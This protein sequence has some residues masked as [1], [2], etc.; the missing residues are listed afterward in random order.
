MNKMEVKTS[1]CTYTIFIE[2]GLLD[3]IEYYLPE[4][5][6]SRKLFLISNPTVYALYGKKLEEQLKKANFII[7]TALMP[8]GEEY[9][10]M[11]EMMKILDQ[12][13]EKQLERNSVILALGGGVVGDLAGFVASIYQRGIDFVQIPTTLLS[14]VDSSVGGKVAVNHSQGKNLIGSFHQP[15]SVIIDPLS[16]LT[17]NDREYRAGLGEV[18]KYGI[19]YDENFFS[20]MEDN[21]SAINNKEIN[22]I[23]ELIFRSCQIKSKIVAEDE[24]EYGVRALLNL[25]HTF[26]HA[27]EK[28]THYQK[29]RHGEAVAMGIVSATFLA[30]DLGL[31]N[32]NEEKRIIDL[33]QGLKIY[34]DYAEL[35]S[36][37][38]YEAMFYDKKVKNQKIRFILPKGIG[39][40]VILN[41]VET[42]KVLK[43][44]EKAKKHSK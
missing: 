10:N 1:S 27:I 16:L 19:I 9:K 30:S 21:L 20:F 4:S 7:Y 31:L 5:F 36:K 15:Y 33:L 24:K 42:A 44:I 6:K 37:D 34:S 13:V 29:Y 8:D 14:Q 32:K 28:L 26:G 38:I 2:E 12:A 43:S 22:I 41:N 3:Q 23:K 40:A 11:N 17:L 18:I 35:E 39:V 25:G